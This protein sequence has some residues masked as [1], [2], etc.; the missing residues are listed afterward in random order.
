[1]QYVASH[2]FSSFARTRSTA[3]AGNNHL[4]AFILFTSIALASAVAVRF[5]FSSL[6]SCC[7]HPNLVWLPDDVFDLNMLV[8]RAPFPPAD[9]DTTPVSD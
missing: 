4:L 7:F 9:L 1:M 2:H 3:G 6:R 8:R 5:P